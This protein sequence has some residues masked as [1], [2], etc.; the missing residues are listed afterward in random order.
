MSAITTHVLDLSRGRPARGIAVV[1]E[2]G[3]AALRRFDDLGLGL[4]MAMNLS[5]HDLFDCRRAVARKKR[6]SPAIR[7]LG[8]QAHPRL[9]VRPAGLIDQLR[10]EFE[11]QA[12]PYGISAD[13]T[14]VCFS[15]WF[16]SH[17]K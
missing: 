11:N 6:Y 13:R 9:T 7:T 2:R 8:P 10:C 4:R 5:T 12:R 14:F 16:C 15:M 17:D 1:L 3:I